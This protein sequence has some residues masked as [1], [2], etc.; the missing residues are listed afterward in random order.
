MKENERPVN[1]EPAG[2][3]RRRLER[4]SA[5]WTAVRVK[6]TRQNKKESLRSDSIGTE[7]ALDA[8]A[9]R[10]QQECRKVRMIGRF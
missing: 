5:K 3:W 7:K 4:F 2:A 9:N 10:P 6:K 8:G 1:R